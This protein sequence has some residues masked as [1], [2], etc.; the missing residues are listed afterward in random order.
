MGQDVL[1]LSFQPKNDAGLPVRRKIDSSANRLVKKIVKVIN[2]GD[3][4]CVSDDYISV[5]LDDWKDDH[6]RNEI[7]RDHVNHKSLEQLNNLGYQATGTINIGRQEWVQNGWCIG[8]STK[9]SFEVYVKIKM[10]E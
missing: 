7:F 8:G 10:D 6:L 1:P 9:Q 2:A 5:R 4:H 3:G